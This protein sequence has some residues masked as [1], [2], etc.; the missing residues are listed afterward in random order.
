MGKMNSTR[1]VPGLREMLERNVVESPMADGWPL[2]YPTHRTKTKTSDRWGTRSFIHRRPAS[3][4]GDLHSV[5]RMSDA[6]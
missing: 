6:R 3:A 2:W 4:V 1:G 5:S